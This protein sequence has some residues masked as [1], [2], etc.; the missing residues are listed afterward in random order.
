MWKIIIFI[1]LVILLFIIMVYYLLR[2]DLE[3]EKQQMHEIYKKK[4]YE[5]INN[6]N[7][8]PYKRGLYGYINPQKD[9]AKL[10]KGDDVLPYDPPRLPNDLGGGQFLNSDFSLPLLTSDLGNIPLM[11]IGSAPLMGFN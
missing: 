6:Q 11:S 9:Q 3:I 1:L 10:F 2:S 7:N 8:E 4:I 5:Y